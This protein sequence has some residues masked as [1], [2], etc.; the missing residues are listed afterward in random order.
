MVRFDS[1]LNTRY[2]NII[3]VFSLSHQFFLEA[4]CSI[5]MQCMVKLK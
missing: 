3:Q 4:H 5:V 1:V 2:C